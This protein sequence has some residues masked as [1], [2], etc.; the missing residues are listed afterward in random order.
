[1]SDPARALNAIAAPCPDVTTTHPASA[2]EHVA[3]ADAVPEPP[4]LPPSAWAAKK[5]TASHLLAGAY[6]ARRSRWERDHASNDLSSCT[7]SEYD[8]A[9]AEVAGAGFSSAYSHK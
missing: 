5:K 2:S 6:V 4:T 1:M 3:V 7:E 8:A 9:I